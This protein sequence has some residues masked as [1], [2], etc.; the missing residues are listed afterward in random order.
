MARLKIT[1]FSTR[2]RGRRTVLISWQLNSP[3]PAKHIDDAGCH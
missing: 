3:P 2:E 1:L